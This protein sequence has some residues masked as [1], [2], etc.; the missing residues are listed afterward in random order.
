MGQ[1]AAGTVTPGSF[2]VQLEAS[3]NAQT[4]TTDAATLANKVTVGI[5]FAART[6]A[7]PLA[8]VI[9][10]AK[11]V[12]AGVTSDTATVTAAEALT[13]AFIA[14]GGNGGSF[15]VG[16]GTTTGAG[17]TGPETF[18]A[19]AGALA[20]GDIVTG[21]GNAGTVANIT[22]ANGTNNLDAN[23]PIVG[24][25]GTHGTVINPIN[26][27]PLLTQ[28]AGYLAPSI[29][30]IPVVNVTT[31]GTGGNLDLINSSG[32]TTV[33]VNGVG[34]LSL[35]DINPRNPDH[36]QRRCELRQHRWWFW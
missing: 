16:H 24:I 19:A 11:I 23:A 35:Y 14:Q 9:A 12:E 32:I 22:L 5:D 27:T 33:G 17:V 21:N 34:D 28:N 7:I 29:T 36:D 30:G 1:L 20:T 31:Q 15:A 13:T 3:V 10:E 8:N 6:S 2:I 4:G 25:L 18:N 26:V